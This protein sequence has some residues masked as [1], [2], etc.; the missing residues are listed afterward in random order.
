MYSKFSCS[1]R[2]EDAHPCSLLI[3]YSFISLF[4]DYLRL[5]MSI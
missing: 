2:S 5:R 1:E 4:I 3:N